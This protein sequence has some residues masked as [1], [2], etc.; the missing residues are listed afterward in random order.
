MAHV[1]LWALVS[2]RLLGEEEC[3]IHDCPPVRTATVT[4]RC[5]VPREHLNGALDFS[6]GADSPKP[7]EYR[8]QQYV[9][10]WSTWLLLRHQKHWSLDRL[11]LHVPAYAT[12]VPD[13]STWLLRKHQKY[14]SLRRHRSECSVTIR[15]QKA[16]SLIP[17]ATRWLELRQ[18]PL[19]SLLC[20]Y[21]GASTDLLRCGPKSLS[22]HEPPRTYRD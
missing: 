13:W 7:T 15:K 1:V 12:R 8:E 16:A 3:V 9:G 22:F 11:S 21:Q 6:K 14:W 2:G 19:A 20:K 18:V 10:D 17:T 5:P 4:E